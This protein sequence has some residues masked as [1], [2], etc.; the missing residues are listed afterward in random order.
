MIVQYPAIFF[1]LPNSWHGPIAG[2]RRKIGSSGCTSV[3]AGISQSLLAFISGYKPFYKSQG[4]GKEKNVKMPH[5]CPSDPQPAAETHIGPWG[6]QKHLM[7][8]LLALM[9]GRKTNVRVVG[10]KNQPC[11][12]NSEHPKISPCIYSLANTLGTIP[13]TCESTD[14]HMSETILENKELFP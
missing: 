5:I 4:T 3:K 6:M 8:M 1:N 9:T 13:S 11:F 10:S 7:E 2:R 12:N 14:K